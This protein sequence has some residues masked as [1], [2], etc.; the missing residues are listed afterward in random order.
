[1]N[2]RTLNRSLPAALKKFL[3]VV[4]AMS[5]L[6]VP[7]PVSACGPFSLEAVF[8][9]SVHPDFPLASFARGEIGVL[10][11]TYAR[12]YLLA[13]YRHMM[14][15]G[16]N[17][18][19]QQALA[20]LWRERLEN[21]WESNDTNWIARWAETRGRV[22]GVGKAPEIGVYRATEK[23]DEHD[24]YLNCHEDAFKT[25]AATLDERI[26]KFGA[27]HPS[28]KEWVAAQDEVFSNCSEG[29]RIPAAVGTDGDPIIRADRAYQIAAAYFYAAR[30]D[31][32]R[33]AFDE[34]ARDDSSPW[35]TNA[36][37]LAARAMLRKGSLSAEP[38]RTEA[39]T[40]A[41][42]QLQSVLD[43]RSLNAS[44]EDARRL[45]G[46][47]RLRLR[48]AERLHELAQSV[49][50]PDAQKS[51]KQDVWDY[52]LLLDKFINDEES[53]EAK[54]FKD[55]PN[56]GRDDDLT[57]WV[58]TFQVSDND[59]LE[60]SVQRWR[61]TSSVAWLVAALSK[62]NGAHAAVPSLLEAASRVQP[63][64]PAYASVAFHSLRLMVETRRED[65][66]RRRLDATLL[67][68]RASLPPSA[69][70]LLLS[71]RMHLAL[72]LEEFL[73]FAQRVPSG[74]TY[75]YDG[76]QVPEDAK[77]IE[78]DKQLQPLMRTPML[79]DGDATGLINRRLP[80][81]L[82]KDAAASR[83]LPDS[84]RTRVAIAAWVR[85]VL[86]DDRATERELVP[87]VLGLVP[88]L[89][90]YADADMDAPANDARKFSALYAMLK[91]SG[92]RPHVDA[93]VGRTTP[94]GEL[95]Q[96]RDNWWCAFTLEARPHGSG[97]DGNNTAWT[98]KSLADTN[99]PARGEATSSLRFL[100]ASQTAAASREAARLSAL[101]AAPNYF[102]R[103][104]VEFANKFPDDPRIPEAL[105]LAVRSTRYGCTDTETGALSKAAHTL[106]HKRYPKSEWAKKTP[107]WFK[108]T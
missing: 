3:L 70:N 51:L 79:F 2:I 17:E 100:S 41:E 54:K 21:V 38:V 26:K 10:Q 61:K 45:L 64:S 30:F 65:E 52:T 66:A 103:L 19:E 92:L 23:P 77:E 37:Y 56:V 59:A 24:S 47:V 49:L 1:M 62:V 85:A 108:G 40:E 8:T 86:L 34:I 43:N 6:A 25:A 35:R 50:R 105:H 36:A 63:A 97:D 39:L 22:A 11:P 16:F 107:Y 7:R 87:V 33:R 53:T 106:L 68:H 98:R 99:R 14:G 27:E 82:L 75:N 4:L 80:L 101:G 74:F 28:L 15:T 13:S 90:G 84:L 81:S 42:K 55:L 67:Q 60:H 20:A 58:M 88:D 95:D 83:A 96:Y 44:H 9:Y 72:N 12:S 73:Q 71:L 104:A 29:R 102:A 76:R 57:D 32:A 69:L 5:L 31:D 18:A 46:L 91:F 94:V 89:K 78:K 48:P 93:G